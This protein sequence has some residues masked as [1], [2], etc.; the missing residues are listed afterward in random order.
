MPIWM[1][2][3][4]VHARTDGMEIIVTR[5]MKQVTT[6]ITSI[7]HTQPLTLTTTMDTLETITTTE[8]I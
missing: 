6:T 4:T 8:A 7:T 2:T 5:L 1:H 3:D